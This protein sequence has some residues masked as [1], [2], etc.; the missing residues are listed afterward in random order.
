MLGTR[1]VNCHITDG[2]VRLAEKGAAPSQQK[3]LDTGWRPVD[4]ATPVGIRVDALGLVE[5]A[6]VCKRL[7]QMIRFIIGNPILPK[8]PGHS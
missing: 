6:S 1:F 8:F 4:C 2:R 5:R 3:E 7:L